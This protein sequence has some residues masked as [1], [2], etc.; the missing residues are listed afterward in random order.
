LYGRIGIL[1]RDFR[2]SCRLPPGRRIESTLPPWRPSR[3]RPQTLNNSDV[4]TL[5]TQGDSTPPLLQPCESTR[6]S[7]DGLAVGVNKRNDGPCRLGFRIPDETGRKKSRLP[8][9]TEQSI[10]KICGTGMP[11]V[12]CRLRL[13]GWWC[14]SGSF[15]R[16]PLPRRKGSA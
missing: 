8:S 6:L 4:A 3:H 13:V 2:E 9:D 12:G 7:R 11:V 5:S 15:E 1:S 10:R 16:F 14:V